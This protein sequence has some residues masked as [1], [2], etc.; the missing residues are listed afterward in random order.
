MKAETGQKVIFKNKNKLDC[1][2][3]TIK[4]EKNEHI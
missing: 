1:K 3:L 2:N 4:T